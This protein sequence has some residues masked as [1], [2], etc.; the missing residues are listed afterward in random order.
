MTGVQRALII[1][2]VT[3]VSKLFYDANGCII[4]YDGIVTASFG[5]RYVVTYDHGDVEM[6]DTFEAGCA[7]MHYRSQHT[8]Q[9]IELAFEDLDEILDS[10]EGT[11][12]S[13]LEK[14]ISQ[15]ADQVRDAVVEP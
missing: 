1:P 14:R 9:L 7:V 15:W 10:V 3:P 6:L 11:E 4:W 13:A 12:P 5:G 8:S 2:G